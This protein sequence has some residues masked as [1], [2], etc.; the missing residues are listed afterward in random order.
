MPSDTGLSLLSTTTFTEFEESL[1]VLMVPGGVGTNGAMRDDDIVEFL[2]RAATSAGRI[3]SVCTG[4]LILG[5]AGL[6]EGRRAATRWAFYDVLEAL[7]AEPVEDRIVL[8]G[9]RI[10]RCA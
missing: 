6:L 3:T 7:G 8:D 4:S 10:W 2:A 1:D 9:D 5:M